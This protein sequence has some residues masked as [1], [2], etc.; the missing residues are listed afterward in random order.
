MDRVEERD[1]LLRPLEIG[2]VY[3]GMEVIEPTRENP[4]RVYRPR[5]SARVALTAEDFKFKPGF[6]AQARALAALV[7]GEDPGPAARLEDAHAALHLAE[8]L[9]GQVYE[10]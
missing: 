9:V 1:Q 10:G 2:T 8:E 3:E 5:E 4:L 6:L 7:H